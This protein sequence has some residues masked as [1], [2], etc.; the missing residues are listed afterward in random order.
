MSDPVPFF[1]GR[2]LS[3]SGKMVLATAED[4]TAKNLLLDG[5]VTLCSEGGKGE[6]SMGKRERS[7]E[8]LDNTANIF[9]VIASDQMTNTYRISCCL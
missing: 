2:D 3:I 9:P 1:G 8:K 6:E 5:N 4:F 7:W